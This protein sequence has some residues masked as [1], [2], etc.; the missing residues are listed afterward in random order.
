MGYV[1]C[2]SIILHATACRSCWP[3]VPT[4]SDGPS[5]RWLCNGR[6]LHALDQCA[7]TSTYAV[8][9]ESG[10]LAK[11]AFFLNKPLSAYCAK[12]SGGERWTISAASVQ[13]DPITL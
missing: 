2:A 11:T 9:S 12:P 6:R 8:R 3:V 5:A 4:I 1:G 7:T 13:L 10:S